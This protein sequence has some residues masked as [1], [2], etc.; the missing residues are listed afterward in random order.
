MEQENFTYDL[1]SS[2]SS[3]EEINYIN[4][5]TKN[6]V[7]CGLILKLTS[8]RPYLSRVRWYLPLSAGGCRREHAQLTSA[9]SLCRISSFEGEVFFLYT[10]L[11]RLPGDSCIIMNCSFYGFDLVLF[12][13]LAIMFKVHMFSDPFWIEAINLFGS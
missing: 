10:R 4:H 13:I 5:V 7:S 3:L 8:S 2:F 1:H 12:F 9:H 11:K 6:I